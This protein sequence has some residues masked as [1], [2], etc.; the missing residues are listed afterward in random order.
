MNRRNPRAFTLPELLVTL[1][2][3]TLFLNA[4]TH[5]FHSSFGMIRAAETSQSDAAKFDH[6]LAALRRDVWE[7]R[8]LSLKDSRELS[9][10]TFAG[11]QVVWVREESAI[12][13]T[14]GDGEAADKQAWKGM[15]PM[16]FE[17]KGQIVTLIAIEPR[18]R[19][20]IDLISP[21]SEAFP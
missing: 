12:T 20:R 5:L 16:E 11:R 8:Q 14:I 17:L 18:G 7:A 3:L 15:P 21:A 10:K 6:F 13:R 9:L 2:L 4:A 19:Q 1:A